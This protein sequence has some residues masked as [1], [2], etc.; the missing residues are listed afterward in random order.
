MDY[1]H[2][3]TANAEASSCSIVEFRLLRHPHPALRAT[4]SALRGGRRKMSSTSQIA[5][6]QGVP[7]FA[8]MTV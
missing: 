8:G 7:A 5:L 1:A 2:L 4:F 3:M 6:I